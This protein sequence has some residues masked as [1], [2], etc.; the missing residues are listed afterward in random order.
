[1][2]RSHHVCLDGCHKEYNGY[3]MAG[4]QGHHGGSMYHCID[5]ALE[6]VPGSGSCKNVHLL[7]TVG[8]VRS[9]VSTTSYALSCAVC[10]K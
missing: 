7:Y 4:H 8:A 1:M 5:E 6:Q 2:I 3:I 10:T 9:Y